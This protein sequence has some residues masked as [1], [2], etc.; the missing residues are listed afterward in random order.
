MGSGNVDGDRIFGLV[1]T[2][3]TLVQKRS[4]RFLSRR[5]HL[6]VPQYRLLMAA[7]EGQEFNLGHMAEEI[8]CSRGNLTGLVD[9]LER[10]GWLRRHRSREDRRVITLELTE[11][12]QRIHEIHAALT[13]YLRP[14]TQAWTPEEIRSTVALLSRMLGKDESLAHVG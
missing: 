7:A 2:I 9:R 1:Q 8:K 4:H 12:G 3:D 10:D 14:L 5:F 6:T 13:A 11:Q